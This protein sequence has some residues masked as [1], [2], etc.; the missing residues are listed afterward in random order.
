MDRW[1]RYLFEKH[2]ETEL[3]EWASR[4]NMFRFFRAFGGHANDADSLDIA[5][6]YESTEALLALLASIGVTPILHERKPDQPIPGRPYRGDEFSA[7]PSLIRGTEWIEQPG[8]C[9]LF[10]VP[11]YIYCGNGLVKVSVGHG[12]W[13]VTNR[14]VKWAEELETH[15]GS[16]SR[17]IVD[18]PR[19]TEHYV[20][21]KY[22][23]DFFAEKSTA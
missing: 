8:H 5:L 4:L 10:G 21:P 7:F 18:P 3:R 1:T 11:V 15:L 14:H 13:E 2:S 23:P 19:D 9:H 17:L 16:V 20:C 22:Y 12:E 6:K